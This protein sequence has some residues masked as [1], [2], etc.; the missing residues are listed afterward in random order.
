M[1]ISCHTHRPRRDALRCQQLWARLTRKQANSEYLNCDPIHIVFVLP[2]FV[3]PLLFIWP[4]IF[5]RFFWTSYF[6]LFVWHIFL[7]HLFDPYFLWP[8]FF[9]AVFYT[10]FVCFFFVRPDID[11]YVFDPFLVETCFWP[12]YVCPIFWGPMYLHPFLLLL[13]LDQFCFD[14]F[15][16]FM[17]CSTILFWNMFFSTRRTSFRQAYTKHG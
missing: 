6:Y 12:V 4:V 1:Y 5:D 16:W 3:W 2:I 14:L 17:F 10:P 9:D 7:T 8:I 11:P 15:F 13:F